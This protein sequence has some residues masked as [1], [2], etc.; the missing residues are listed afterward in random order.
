MGLVARVVSLEDLDSAMEVEVAAYLGAAPGAVAASKRL[1]RS[2][3][4]RIDPETIERSIAALANAWE[5]P[6]AHEGVAAFFD[7]RTPGWVVKSDE[8]ST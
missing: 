7:R 1:A 2:L 6:E 4:P 8:G 3:G 5:E